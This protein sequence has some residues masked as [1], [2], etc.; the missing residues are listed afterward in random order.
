MNRAEHLKWAKDRAL[1]YAEQ[2][3]TAMAIASLTSDLGKHEETVGHSG[4]MLMTML[5]MNGDFEKPGRLAEF[6]KGFQ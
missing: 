3:D 2:G 6:I 4:V 5:A 1:E